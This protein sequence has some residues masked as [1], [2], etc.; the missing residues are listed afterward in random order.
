MVWYLHPIMKGASGWGSAGVHDAADFSGLPTSIRNLAL[1]IACRSIDL[2]GKAVV[3][4]VW[5]RM[6]CN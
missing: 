5:D 2:P 3:C 6:D 4:V 1:K